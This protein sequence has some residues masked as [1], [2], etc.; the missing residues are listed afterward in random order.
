MMLAAAYQ[1]SFSNHLC[2]TN[3]IVGNT[4]FGG[5]DHLKV[6]YTIFLIFH[7]C[8]AT[9]GAV[10]GVVTINAGLK[11]NL[12]RHRKWSIQCYL[13][14]HSNYRCCCLFTSLRFY[15]G[16][17]DVMFKAILV[18]TKKRFHNICESVFV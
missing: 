16:G 2:V 1:H 15:K 14:L 6:Y 12:V 4:A 7:I 17:E 8:L 5:P 11:N 10:L 9:T 18:L 3:Y 13:V